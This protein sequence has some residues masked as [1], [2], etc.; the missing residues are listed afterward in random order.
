MPTYL[1]AYL[2]NIVGDRFPIQ[3]SIYKLK[4]TGGRKQLRCVDLLVATVLADEHPDA[5]TTLCH[6][7]QALPAGGPLTLGMLGMVEMSG[8]VGMSGMQVMLVPCR[9]DHNCDSHQKGKAM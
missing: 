4:V 2:T 3:R 7:E 9:E 1:P 6:H 5:G 8:M